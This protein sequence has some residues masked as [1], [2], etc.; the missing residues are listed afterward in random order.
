M[1]WGKVARNHHGKAH[2]SPRPERLAGDD[3]PNAYATCTDSD[4][5]HQQGYE[6]DKVVFKKEPST[7]KK[8]GVL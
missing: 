6:L 8:G 1:D 7:L 3:P 5:S 2:G 4:N